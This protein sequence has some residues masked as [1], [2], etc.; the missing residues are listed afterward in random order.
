M[1]K[2]VNHLSTIQNEEKR[3]T[4]DD[5]KGKEEKNPLNKVDGIHS[6]K[7]RYKNADEIYD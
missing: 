7:L 3:E 5:N 4:N 6:E 1:K 2:D